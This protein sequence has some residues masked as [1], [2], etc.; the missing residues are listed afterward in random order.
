MTKSTKNEADETIKNGLET[1][2]YVSGEKQSEGKYK[3]NKKE[4]KWTSWDSKGNIITQ[5]SFKG[6]QKSGKWEESDRQSTFRGNY[7]SDK[8]EGKWTQ[9]WLGEKQEEKYY[10]ADEITRKI[11]YY[12]ENQKRDDKDYIKQHVIW[13]HKNGQKQ[14]EGHFNDKGSNGQWNKWYENG[15]LESKGSYEGGSEIGKWT[16]WYDDGQ[17]HSEGCYKDKRRDGQWT[18]WHENGQKSAKGSFASNSYIFGMIHGEG[19][20]KDGRDNIAVWK[21]KKEEQ[22]DGKWTY[23]HSNGLKAAEGCYGNKD[24]SQEGNLKKDFSGD[25]PFGESPSVEISNTYTFC[26][27]KN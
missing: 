11:Y 6:G 18:Y 9:I 2:F 21:G 15:Q 19:V 3:D 5:G 1:L 25:W 24:F 23:W 13:W 8:K 22:K 16:Y 14:K 27:E 17:K 4:G 10:S 12:D 7:K 26:N 20:D